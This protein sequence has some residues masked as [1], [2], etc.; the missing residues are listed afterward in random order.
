MTSKAHV[1]T[2]VVYTHVNYEKIL[3]ATSNTSMDRE[4][5]SF[6]RELTRKEILRE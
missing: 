4:S 3:Y 1:D 6:P 5:I 2:C